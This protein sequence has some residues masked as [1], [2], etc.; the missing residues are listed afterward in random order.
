LGV[1]W[2]G[3]EYA[4]DAALVKMINELRPDFVFSGHIHNSPFR[5][6]GAWASRL[7][8]T[9]VFNAGRQLGA[10]PAYIELD[11]E[12]R[13]AR[14]VSQAGMEEIQLDGPAPGESVPGS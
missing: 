4:G 8:P 12:R 3:K 14:W 1:S 9:W 6:G 13:S 7:G 10:P 11:L 5:A 2:T